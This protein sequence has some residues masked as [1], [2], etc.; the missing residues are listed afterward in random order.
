MEEILA[1]I[2]IRPFTSD[3]LPG[4][5]YGSRTRT[6][7]L[8]R[9]DGS[10]AYYDQHRHVTGNTN[11]GNPRNASTTNG[12]ISTNSNSHSRRRRGRKDDTGMDAG[13]G[14]QGGEMT[15]GPIQGPVHVVQPV[16]ARDEQ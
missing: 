10:V 1:P 8:M 14:H 9:W 4:G 5:Y 16:A 7:V 12:A 2:H 11:I 15:W 6:V 3:S 13:H